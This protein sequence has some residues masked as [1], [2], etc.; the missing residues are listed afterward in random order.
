MTV[1]GAKG[2]EFSHVFLLRVNKTSSAPERSHVFEF[3]G[4]LMKEGVPEIHFHHQESAGCT[5]WR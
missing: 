3:P 1:H 5:T 4:R 2:L